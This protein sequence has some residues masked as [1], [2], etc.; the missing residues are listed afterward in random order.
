MIGDV[1]GLA[2]SASVLLQGCDLLCERDERVLF[3][4]LNFSV[5]AGTV[6]QI[7]GPNGSGKTTLLRILAG[8]SSNYEGEIYF[9]GQSIKAQAYEYR[10]A[11]CSLGH[12]PG[13]KAMLSPRENL[14][15]ALSL[16]TT[17]SADDIDEALCAVGLWGFEDVPAYSL[18]AGQHRRVALA[19]LYLSQAPIWILDEPF[20]AIDKA[21]VAELEQL[22]TAHAKRGGAVILTT[23]HHLNLEA[24]LEVLSLGGAL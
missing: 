4:S 17:V 6:L 2:S 7:E 10:K 11:L 15:W 24:G 9:K 13:V 19:R 16:S 12:A 23:H 8:L 3:S 22:L 14:R 5:S 18:S 21:G 20:T 1:D